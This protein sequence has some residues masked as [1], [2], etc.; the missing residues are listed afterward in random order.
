MYVVCVC[1]SSIDYPI[2]IGHPWIVLKDELPAEIIEKVKY[3]VN[4]DT[5]ED[6]LRDFMN[7]M[8]LVRKEVLYLV[9]LYWYMCILLAIYSATC[10]CFIRLN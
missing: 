2:I 6:K 7:W 9:T 1:I 3:R 5:P 4:R 10:A 8:V